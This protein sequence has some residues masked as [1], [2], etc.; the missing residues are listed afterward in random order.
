IESNYIASV[1]KN[2]QNEFVIVYHELSTGETQLILIENTFD[3]VIHELGKQKIKEVVIDPDFPKSY[4]IQ[5]EKQLQTLLSFENDV[6]LIG[7]FRHLY[8]D[9]DDERYL[10]GFSRML[11]YIVNTQKRSL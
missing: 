10:H 6:N 9:F 3:A 1:T 2:K 11:N 7:E 8:E 5:L 4:Q